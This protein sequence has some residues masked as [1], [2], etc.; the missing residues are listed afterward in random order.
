MAEGYGLKYGAVIVAAGSGRRMGEGLPKQFRML[1][2]LPVLGHSINLFARAMKGIEIVVVLP[3][4]REEF[5][6]NFAARFDIAAH[7]CVT[8]GDE[9]FHSVR[10]GIGA[11]SAAVDLVAVHD[12]VRPLASEELVQRCF[13]CAADNGTAVPVVA[14]ADSYR[15]LTADGNSAATDR[16][17]LRIVQTPQ[18]FGADMLRSAYEKPFSADFTDDAT[19][20]EHSLRMAV[21]LCDGERTNIKLTCPDDFAVAEAIISRR[22]ETDTDERI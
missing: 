11:L 14:P 8:G 9:R 7:R 17:R 4:G 10:A 21:T 2:G 15:I 13:A 12:G 18:V 20:V 6:R 22:N 16:S 19:L 5:W 3:A 1:G